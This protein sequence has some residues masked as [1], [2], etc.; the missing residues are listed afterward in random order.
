[1]G[2][3]GSKKIVSIGKALQNVPDPDENHNLK[4]HV[5]TKYKVKYN[6]YISNRKINPDKPSP[7]ITA[8]GDHKGGA[9]II[10]HPYKERRL[11]CRELAI[12]QG[13]PLDF[14]FCGS[15]T[16]A[17]IQ[18]GNAV[19][20]PLAEAVASSIQALLST[21]DGDFFAR[22]PILETVSSNETESVQ[23]TLF[24]K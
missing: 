7:T 12:I 16:S 22:S 11:S 1:M 8:R 20:P 24:F 14:E 5:Y 10:H 21:A 15:M 4:N 19:P 17:Y 23:A 3:T 2:D 6:G 9:M 13:F 18:I